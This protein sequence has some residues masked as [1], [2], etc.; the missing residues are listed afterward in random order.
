MQVMIFN[1]NLL[2]IFL[3]MLFF[4]QYSR[5]I[6][7]VLG[8]KYKIILSSENEGE[9]LFLV[10][11]FLQLT[12]LLCLRAGTVGDDTHVYLDLYHSGVNGLSNLSNSHIEKGA[13]IYVW[14]LSRWGRND[15]LFLSAFAVPTIILNYRFIRKYS[16][17][18]YMSVFIFTGLMYYFLAFNMMRQSLAMAIVLQAMQPAMERKW[19]KF[20]LV[21]AFASIFHTSAW[22]FLGFIL[23]PFIKVKINMG[24]FIGVV[25]VSVLILC[26][27]RKAV[28]IFLGVLGS[29]Y[30]HYLNQPLAGGNGHILH[31]VMYLLILC[32]VILLW[33]N[34]AKRVNYIFIHMLFIGT[35]LYVLSIRIQ[36]VNRLPYYFTIAV[37]VLLPNLIKRIRN[38]KM[39]LFITVGVY[40]CV[41]FYE[42]LITLV[43]K[44]AQGILPYVF[45]W[46]K[47][48]AHR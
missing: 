41:A 14:L 17:N 43:L 33:K 37:I 6:K 40:F 34:E 36:I 23:L 30:A 22:I 27:G 42:V 21:I 28:S 19:G 15:V 24:Y 20:I 18:I 32:L 47:Y 16:D 11:T 5:K 12:M 26:I 13:Q 35:M 3:E 8:R 45:F 10:I 38:R 46:E 2:L 29:S 44:K 4:R 25:V 31:P 7:V 39:Y 1:F 9:L 48:A